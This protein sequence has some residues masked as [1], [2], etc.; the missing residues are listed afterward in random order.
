MK[1][2]IQRVSEA[3]VEVDGKIVGEIGP[4]LVILLGVARD[5]E[6]ADADYLAEKIPHLRIFNDSESKMNLSLVETGGEMLAGSQFTLYAST[7]KGRRPSFVEAAPP[8]QG[9]PLYNY[10]VEKLRRQNLRVATGIFGAMM[11]VKIVNDG[12]VTIIMD[13]KDRLKPRKAVH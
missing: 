7:R 8:E 10:F 4:G 1:A 9:E 3:S 6:P 12:P 5:D 13:S 11:R 2:V